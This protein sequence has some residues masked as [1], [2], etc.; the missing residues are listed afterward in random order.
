MSP[1]PQR[2]LTDFRILQPVA[3]V[4]A[5][6]IVLIS[7]PYCG[8]FPAVITAITSVGAVLVFLMPFCAGGPSAPR[9]VRIALWLAGPIV[10]IWSLLN[11]FQSLPIAQH[12]SATTSR[13]FDYVR[14]MFSG[15]AL[16]IFLLLILS[17]E[18]A[19]LS[20]RQRTEN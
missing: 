15:M 10:L 9:W 6:V 3:A 19:K 14:P 18:L 11:L 7:F 13:F 8:L 16:G 1:S 5:L 12:F 20:R 2:A 4:C 17:G